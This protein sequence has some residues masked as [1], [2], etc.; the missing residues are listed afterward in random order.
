MKYIALIFLV[1]CLS[2]FEAIAQ[3]NCGNGLPCGSLPWDIPQF[4]PLRSPTPLQDGL[5]NTQP[6]AT[7]TPLPTATPLD[8]D[9]PI[10]EVAD[11]IATV[12]AVVDATPDF[13]L[14]PIDVSLMSEIQTQSQTFFSYAKGFGEASFGPVAP[15]I[16]F[17]LFLFSIT[18]FS[19]LIRLTLPF[20]A[21]LIGV[22]IKIA[23]IITMAIQFLIQ[24]VVSGIR[25]GLGG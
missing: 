1:L 23:Q 18:M 3:S 13:V 7:P 19:L 25:A 2:Q 8:A 5:Q 14:T 15:I 6:T 21:I 20:L 24:A 22:F 12:Q 9:L 10:D 17:L 16:T 11:F 4:A